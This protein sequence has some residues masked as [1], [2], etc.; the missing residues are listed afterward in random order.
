MPFK[1]KQGQHA[2]VCLT[3]TEFSDV[4]VGKYTWVFHLEIYFENTNIFVF[5]YCLEQDNL[6]AVFTLSPYWFLKSTSSPGKMQNCPVN[7]NFQ[8]GFYFR[9]VSIRN[10]H[11]KTYN[12]F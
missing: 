9:F 6:D 1:K 11:F 3:P 5:S 10:R 2:H 12:L 8:G 7:S 4:S